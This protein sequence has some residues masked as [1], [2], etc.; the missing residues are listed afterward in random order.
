[1]KDYITAILY[2]RSYFG[3]K[4][5]TKNI[6]IFLIVIL[7]VLLPIGLI[8][9]WWFAPSN[10]KNIYIGTEDYNFDYKEMNEEAF[11]WHEAYK[12][13]MCDYMENNGLVLK[14]GTYRIGQGEKFNDAVEIFNFLLIIEDENYDWEDVK[15]GNTWI[16]WIAKQRLIYYMKKK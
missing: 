11:L 13:E 1:M 3:M 14:P 8:I 15:D 12:L 2:R 10:F 4:K 6:I 5:K 16:K 7:I 9:N